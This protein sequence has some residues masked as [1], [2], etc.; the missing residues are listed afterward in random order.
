MKLKDLV[1]GTLVAVLGLG[2]L[3]ANAQER[4][5]VV[6]R[7]AIEQAV[8]NKVRTDEGERAAIRALLQR[9]EVKQ[10]ADDLGVDLRRADSKVASLEGKQLHQTAAQAAAA[11][12]ALVGGATTIQISVVTL[13][14]II[15][16]IILLAD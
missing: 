15:I 3:P 6:D 8:A 2:A 7:T 5:V 1:A 16:I 11:N 4:G 13:L 12:D 14:L 10:V 9:S